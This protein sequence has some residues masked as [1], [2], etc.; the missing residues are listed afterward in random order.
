[1]K[2]ALTVIKNIFM[3]ILV[4]IAICIMAFTIISVAT[5]DR[6]DR[7]IFGYK[8]FIVLSDSMKATD[9]DAGDVVV[10]KNTD[11][12]TLQPGDIISYTSQNTSNLGETVTHKIRKPAVDAKGNPGFITY[13]TTTDVDDEIVVTYPYINGKYQFRLAKVGL[14]FQFL[15]TTPGY[16]ICIL[17]PFLLLIIL[18]GINTIKLFRRYKSEQM[19][20]LQNERAEIAEERKKSE[21]MLAELQALKAQLAEQQN[22]QNSQQDIGDN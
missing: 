8:A 18:Q 15:K 6:N 14:F 12:A 21:E 22:Q 11:P 17:I 20:E 16:I 3:W 2:T 13:G 10:V 1:M 5:F 19:L 9:F 4:I 7:N